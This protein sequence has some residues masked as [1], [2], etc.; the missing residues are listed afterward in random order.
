MGAPSINKLEFGQAGP[1]PSRALRP[2]CHPPRVRGYSFPTVSNTET[3]GE[4]DSTVCAWPRGSIA[5][6]GLS[7]AFA[8]VRLIFLIPPPFSFP[9]VLPRVADKPPREAK[10]R[11]STYGP[12]CTTRGRAPQGCGPLMGYRQAGL[13]S[14]LPYRLRCLNVLAD[15]ASAIFNFVSLHLVRDSAGAYVPMGR[16]WPYGLVVG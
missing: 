3:G 8:P 4:H 2:C 1:Q 16:G 9:V 10:T 15:F 6:G 11:L 13:H 12:T 7:W 5:V 14:H